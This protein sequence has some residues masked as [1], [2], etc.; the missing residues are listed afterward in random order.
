[1]NSGAGRT[2]VHLG[3]GAIGG[4]LALAVLSPRY[5][6]Y[7]LRR[8]PVLIQYDSTKSCVADGWQVNQCKPMYCGTIG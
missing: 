5:Y 1:M 2:I 8:R 3:I 6:K 4:M 7:T